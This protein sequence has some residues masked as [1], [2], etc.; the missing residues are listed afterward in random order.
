MPKSRDISRKTAQTLPASNRPGPKLLQ[1]R[2]SGAFTGTSGVAAVDEDLSGSYL[3]TELL[4][5][6]ANLERE[7]VD[8]SKPMKS[9][10]DALVQQLEASA[11]TTR[12]SAVLLDSC[13]GEEE[14]GLM[15]LAAKPRLQSNY[16]KAATT[17]AGTN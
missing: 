9:E 7:Q 16:S 17:L 10:L 6:S 14:L 5:L 11:T 1:Q 3:T 13:L 2:L 4:E 15:L 12:A 8:A